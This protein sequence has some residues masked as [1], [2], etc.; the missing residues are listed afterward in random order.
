MQFSRY[1]LPLTPVHFDGVKIVRK[2]TSQP[3]EVLYRINASETRELSN[4]NPHARREQWDTRF[5]QAYALPETA[6][7][8]WHGFAHL[9]RKCRNT[10]SQ[11]CKPLRAGRGRLK[12]WCSSFWSARWRLRSR[13]DV[14][15]ISH[16]NCREKLKCHMRWG[17]SSTTESVVLNCAG[18]SVRGGCGKNF[19]R[20]LF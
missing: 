16:D 5:G 12:N 18:V 9:W 6:N 8:S 3:R 1:V 11:R 17:K 15:W 2:I 14:P 10:L 4:C 19:S 7:W 13:E 20:V